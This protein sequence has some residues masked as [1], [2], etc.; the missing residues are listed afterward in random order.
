M[1]HNGRGC[2]IGSARRKGKYSYWYG[3][4]PQIVQK[5]KNRNVLRSSHGKF[6][7]VAE[8]VAHQA[9]VETNSGHRP[10]NRKKSAA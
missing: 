7:N 8:L 2:K 10:Q 1:A 6:K 3:A 4:H 5:R 9:Q